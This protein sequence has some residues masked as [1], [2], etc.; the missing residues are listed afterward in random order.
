MSKKKSKNL[1]GLTNLKNV[2][3]NEKSLLE[4]IFWHIVIVCCFVFQGAFFAGGLFFLTSL[5]LIYILIR[6]PYKIKLDFNLIC[7][8]CMLILAVVSFFLKSIDKYESFVDLQKYIV[9]FLSY[10]AFINMRKVDSVEKGFY[11]GIFI[12]MLCGLL[13]VTGIELFSPMITEKG[14]RLQSFLQYANTTALFMGSGVFLS[15][16]RLFKTKKY[17]YILFSC[18]FAISLFLTQSRITFITFICVFLLYVLLSLHKKYRLILCGVLFASVLII[19]CVGGRIARISL[20]EPTLVERV[21]TYFDAI[22]AIVL[23]PIFGIGLGNWQYLSFSFQSAPYQVKYIHNLYLQVAL[24]A[25]II[26]ALAMFIVV[27]SNIIKNFKKKNIYYYIFIFVVLQSAFEV[28]FNYGIFD[29]FFALL[30]VLINKNNPEQQNEYQV[31]ITKTIKYLKN[32][33]TVCCI[34]YLCLLGIAETFVTLGNYAM[35]QGQLIRAES[36]YQN[37]YTINSH[38][39][40][41]LF[42]LAQTERNPDKAI[43]YLENSLQKNPY[44]FM[45]KNS[46]I[47][48]YLYRGD[49]NEAIEAS[50]SLLESFPYNKAFQELNK[51]TITMAY[52]NGY[53]DEV[54]YQSHIQRHE[55]YI[56]EKNSQITPLYVHIDKDMNY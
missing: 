49:Y 25:G 22:K 24:D 48:G 17:K 6:L 15:I 39:N 42:K 4:I 18:L 14:Q 50:T 47:E 55:S 44:Q 54:S 53:L 28:N 21:I 11:I 38:N 45:A 37:S 3:N 34:A 16:D 19:L 12:T 2:Q 56:K 51:R 52:M 31:N 8:G 5:C 30:L 46:L 29:M 20:F 43:A 13:G 36:L 35:K 41:V 40:T 23:K 9:L 1:N 27:A 32:T 10:F 26:A 33:V 7:L